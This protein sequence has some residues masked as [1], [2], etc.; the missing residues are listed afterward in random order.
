MP[1]KKDVKYTAL[2][3]LLALR[4]DEFFSILSY[5]AKE[6]AEVEKAAFNFLSLIIKSKP[7]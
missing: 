7:L 3:K 6:A 5:G 1:P 2:R 4:D